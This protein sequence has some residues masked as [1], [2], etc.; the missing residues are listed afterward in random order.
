MFTQLIDPLDNLTL[1]CLVALIPVVSLLV[2]LAV[3][4][5]PAWLA[6]LLGSIITFALASWVW[7]MP[8]DNGSHAYVYGRRPACGTLTGSPSGAWCS[9]T[10]WGER[11]VRE[12]PP[13]ADRTRR[14]GR[15]RTDHAVRVG[16][17]GAARGLVGFGYPWA[18]V[19]PILISLGIST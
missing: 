16:L 9:S 8:F 5:L 18:V 2:M 4:R 7:K 11:P 6:T 1:T 15:T 14:H 17:R 3:F 10:R 19:A 13:L 12:F